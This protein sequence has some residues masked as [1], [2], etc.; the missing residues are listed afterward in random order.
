MNLS[1]NIKAEQ[2]IYLAEEAANR[3]CEKKRPK[4]LEKSKG[5]AVFL[6]REVVAHTKSLFSVLLIALPSMKQLVCS[7][8]DFLHGRMAQDAL[9]KMVEGYYLKNDYQHLILELLNYPDSCKAQERAWQQMGEEQAQQNLWTYIN[10]NMPQE[11]WDACYDRFLT[12]H[13]VARSENRQEA[14]GEML[15]RW[16]KQLYGVELDE[17]PWCNTEQL[18]KDLEEMAQTWLECC[19]L[20]QHALATLTEEEI[21]QEVRSSCTRFTQFTNKAKQ[22]NEQWKTRIAAALQDWERGLPNWMELNLLCA[23]PLHT[24]HV[25]LRIVLRLAVYETCLQQWPRLAPLLVPLQAQSQH[26]WD[27][28]CALMNEVGALRGRLLAHLRKEH[29]EVSLMLPFPLLL[30]VRDNER[31]PQAAPRST[32][33]LLPISVAHHLSLRLTNWLSEPMLK[34]KQ[35]R[36]SYVVAHRADCSELSRWMRYA[37]IDSTATSSELEQRLNNWPISVVLA[38]QPF[39]LLARRWSLSHQ[40]FQMVTHSAVL[41]AYLSKGRLWCFLSPTARSMDL[42]ALTTEL[43]QAYSEAERLLL[44]H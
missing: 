26:D 31:L 8:L 37:Y 13:S 11:E 43:L 42:E 17:M 25:Q 16:C 6:R 41:T 36:S 39:P 5:K 9:Q 28:T 38:E 35:K 27:N 14:W 7:T 29:Q 33:E 34:P 18:W 10:E 40:E 4:K 44:L 30:W 20:L 2:E 22:L 23:L 12:M 24:E 15:D 1:A 21:V 32:S 19:W 3:S